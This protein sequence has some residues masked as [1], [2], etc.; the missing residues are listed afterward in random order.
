MSQSLYEE[1]AA[2]ERPES[3]AEE[4]RRLPQTQELAVVA[5]VH[6]GAACLSTCIINPEENINLKKLP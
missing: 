6:Q 1:A 2:A 5:A 3:D 4:L